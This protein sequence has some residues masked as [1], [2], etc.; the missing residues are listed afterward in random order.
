MTHACGEE[1]RLL[2]V[3]DEAPTLLPLLAERL[4][5]LGFS[6]AGEAEPEKALQAVKAGQPDAIL[7]DLH[8]PGDAREGRS[9][10]GRLLAEMRH[11]FPAVA[12][13][14]F[15][16]RL[17]DFDIPLERFKERPQGYFAKPDFVRDGE[18]AGQL[19]QM[20]RNAVAAARQVDAPDVGDLG[21]PAG[22]SPEMRS[23]AEAIR[24]AAGHGLPVLI[25][26][27][28][29]TGKRQ[30]AEAVHRLS[31]RRGRFES[32]RCS[33][34]GGA[35]AEALFGREGD[36]S[37]GAWQGP[38]ELADGGT[39]FLDG[40]DRLPMDLQDG[41]LRTVEDGALR[42]SGATSDTHV[43]VRWIAATSH[44]LDDLVAD[45]TLREE[46]A[47]RFA[48]GTPVFLP[49][50]RR[51]LCDLPDLYAVIV[52]RANDEKVGRR[53][54][55]ALRPETQ[56]KLQTH[57]WPGNI[58]ELEAVLF[59]A[60]ATTNSNVLLPDDIEFIE[61]APPGASGAAATS[62]RSSE[63]EPSSAAIAVAAL[64]D[65]LEGLPVAERYKFLKGQGEGQRR[66][67]LLEF[68]R[69]LREARGQS[70]QHKVLAAELDPLE[71]TERDLNRIRQFLHNCGVRLTQLDFN[72]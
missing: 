23:A 57:G 37:A 61:I 1:M 44:G 72:R 59:R 53:I 38:L 68:I 14:V 56:E 58:R 51:R 46:L 40:L 28:T 32:Y 30:A 16:V 70:I 63:P 69:R 33:V 54:S 13:V 48:G 8:F 7:L 3:D 50:L 18:W 5:P 39:F 43:D 34:A 45:G 64:V 24:G 65:E 35:A 9:T 29:G 42:R 27:E 55:T 67:V 4:E 21:F 19:G 17:S 71:D 11:C 36:G 15:T 49:P 52:G 10:G 20:L 47:F 26:G 31:G 66:K 25:F 41:L 12:V 60:A 2:L 6:V 22:R 62:E